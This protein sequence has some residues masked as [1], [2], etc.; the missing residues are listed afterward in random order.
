MSDIKA[1]SYNEYKDNNNTAS[2]DTEN[3]LIQTGIAYP[4]S[5]NA[6][7][8]SAFASE[9]IDGSV[10]EFAGHSTGDFNPNDYKLIEIHVYK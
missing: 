10:I 3:G 5:W 8:G 2:F 4:N 1:H 9:N 7:H 6:K